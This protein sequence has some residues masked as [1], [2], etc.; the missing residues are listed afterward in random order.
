[1]TPTLIP[2]TKVPGLYLMQERC[3]DLCLKATNADPNILR[4]F[5]DT[6]YSSYRRIQS[7]CKDCPTG[8]ERAGG[9]PPPREKDGRVG[10]GCHKGEQRNPPKDLTWLWMGK[11]TSERDWFRAMLEKFG[12][13]KG[14]A[15]SLHGYVSRDCLRRRALDCGFEFHKGKKWAQS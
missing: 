10:N 12:S 3:V 11:F 4:C 6:G 13:V 2:C 9:K 8:L 14:I 7:R 15:E 5:G 1:M